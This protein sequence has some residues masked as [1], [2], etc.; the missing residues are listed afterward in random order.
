MKKFTAFILSLITLV[1]FAM[2]F[3]AMADET[4]SVFTPS[5]EVKETPEIEQNTAVDPSTG[6]TMNYIATVVEEDM[7]AANLSEWEIRGLVDEFSLWVTSIAEAYVGTENTNPRKEE[8]DKTLIEAYE[9]VQKASDSN[10]KTVWKQ[11]NISNELDSVAKVIYYSND[12]YKS[13]YKTFDASSFVVTDFFDITVNESYEEFVNRS[14]ENYLRVTFTDIY[15]PEEITVIHK[16]ADKG[17]V[18]VP[19]DCILIDGTNL[20][21]CFSSLCPVAFL[22]ISEAKVVEKSSFPLWAIILIIILVLI[23]I[24]IIILLIV[25]KKNDKEDEDETD[26]ENENANE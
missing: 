1:S 26:S 23:L 7:E 9:E 15:K 2:P 3:T 20:T 25:K 10:G 22:R 19:S 24:L 5:V 21:V 13:N 12:E 14:D 4:D 8:T 18:V 11:L 17:W 16:T 6:A